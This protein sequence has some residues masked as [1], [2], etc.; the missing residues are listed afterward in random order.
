MFSASFPQRFA[1]ARN[2]LLCHD[3][4]AGCAV[5][6]ACLADLRHLARPAAQFCP[7][8]GGRGNGSTPCGSCQKKP[9]PLAHLH[10]SFFYEPPLAG[11]LHQYK[12]LGKID[13][14]AALCGMMLAC[15]PAHLAASPPD[16]VLAMPLSRTRRIE[17]G[18]NQCDL[19][20]EAVSRRFSLPLLPHGAV[21]RRP[22]PPQSTLPYAERR[23]NVHGIFRAEPNV[24][25][26]KILIIDD[27]FTSGSTIFEL[28][29]TLRQAGAA[30]ISGW[31]LA[32]A[33][34]Q[35]S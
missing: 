27:V 24:K 35:K 20:A 8:C 19:L 31:V 23:K 14:A 12:H 17:R 33:G 28:A 13:L 22:T 15:P 29:R 16:A 5:C 18:F 6:T 11:I 34:M 2:C 1:A 21:F 30:E 3:S 25:N 10:A 9:P 4:R 7:Q 26:R 32:Q